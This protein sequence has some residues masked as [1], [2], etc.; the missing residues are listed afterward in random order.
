MRVHA[1]AMKTKQLLF[2]GM[3]LIGFLLVQFLQVN[4]APVVHALPPRPTAVPSPA[5]AKLDGGFLELHVEGLAVEE[6]WT[7]VQWKDAQGGWHD[8]QGW[9]G[10]LDEGN[11]KTWWVGAED[12]GTGPF[13]WKVTSDGKVLGTSE[14]FLL[15]AQPGE[16]LQVT[17][18]LD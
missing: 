12:L 13:H 8:V 18:S 2:P 7:I 6:L 15:P 14:E 17:V 9:Q 1:R 4:K 10:T 3:L 5:R 11:I 16:K